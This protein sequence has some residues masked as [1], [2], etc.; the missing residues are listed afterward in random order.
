MTVAMTKGNPKSKRYTFSFDDRSITLTYKN[1]KVTTA[2]VFIRL[3]WGLS[4]VQND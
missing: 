4:I 1:I 3:D 2:I